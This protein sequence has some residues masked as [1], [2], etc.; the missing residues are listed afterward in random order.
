M[1]IALE[2]VQ[3]IARLAHL[4]FTKGETERLR[5]QLDQILDYIDKLGEL[6]TD[7]VEP[8]LGAAADPLCG[9]RDDSLAAT[10]S[11]DEALT[12]APESGRGH[13]KVPKVIT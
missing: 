2:D 3:R 13:F 7:H 4:R 6:N 9:L 12:N 8:A 11:P 10:L 5:A 1:K